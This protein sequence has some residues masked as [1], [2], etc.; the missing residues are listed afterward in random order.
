[1]FSTTTNQF[2]NNPTAN[3]FFTGTPL[4]AS[5]ISNLSLHSVHLSPEELAAIDHGLMSVYGN[6]NAGSAGA[7]SDK[8]NNNAGKYNGLFNT[9]MNKINTGNINNKVNYGYNTPTPTPAIFN[10]QSGKNNINN[11]NNNNNNIFSGSINNNQQQQQQQQQ[12]NTPYTPYTPYAHTPFTPYPQNTLPPQ[13]QQQQ[14]FDAI[15]RQK[16]EL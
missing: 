2:Y 3:P 11:I 12:Q 6:G 8:E 9:P 14:D 16:R 1:M 10:D 5:S 7:T 15:L 4:G 13:Q